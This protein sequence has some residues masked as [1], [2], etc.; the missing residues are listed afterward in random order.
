M[1]EVNPEDIVS[2]G[3][4]ESTG[5]FESSYTILQEESKL[6]LEDREN[7]DIILMRKW[8][9][10]SVLFFIAAIVV[11]DMVLVLL[12]G[13]EK[14]TFKDPNVVMAVV[15]DG[16]LKIV[17]LGYLITENIFKKIFLINKLNQD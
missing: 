3:L 7:Q 1:T 4:E 13:F 14:L 6:S 16:L 8:W 17:G 15:A 12:Y 2:G 11:F 10:Y 9:G 5:S